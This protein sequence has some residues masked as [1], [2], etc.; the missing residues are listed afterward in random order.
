MKISTLKRSL[1]LTRAA[2]ITPFIWGHRG[3]GKSSIVQQFCE[4]NQLGFVDFRVS[5][6]E[7]SDLRGLPD[8]QA[9]RTVFLPP[10]EMP[11][12][13]LTWDEANKMLEQEEEAAKA[14]NRA[15]NVFAMR[16]LL[17]PRL[18][19]GILFLDETNRGQDD[20]LQAIFQLVLDRRVG[21][22]TLPPGWT[23]ICA[24]NF[25]EGYQTNGFTDPAFL[26]R[27][28][29]LIL[30]C[31]DQTLPEWVEFMSAKYEGSATKVIEFASQD[32]KHLKGDVKGELGFSVLP[33]P[34]SW[35]MV[36]RVT[37]VLNS[38]G[39]GGK[40]IDYG[41]DARM[42]VISGL[43]GKELALSFDNYDC[44]VKP[45]QVI[46]RGMEIMGPQISN[47]TRA[48]LTGL[49]WGLA[50]FLKRNIQD[51]KIGDLA[52]AYAKFLCKQQY[53]DIATAFC[54]LMVQGGQST[55]R[56][57]T[58][59]LS[60]PNVAKLLGKFNPSGKDFA[61]RMTRDS[62]LSQLTSKASWGA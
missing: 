43:V 59:M 52:I 30:S 46:D 35:E 45:Q 48:Q 51:D 4:E 10:A 17:Q 58:S 61:S 9:G 1:A 33:S 21:L 20:V 7:A 55:Q 28:C 49:T 16:T 8:K 56:V 27:F 32:L 11:K 26:N 39:E 12:G 37:E 60:N 50:G 42:D 14:E 31:D 15:S 3:I 47:L 57:R 22:Y 38:G 40:S 41:D 62:E 53:K 29:H 36:A 18:Q 19:K 24:G 5:Q 34:R 2:Q 54:A 13:D 25:N 23:V 6:I 44:P